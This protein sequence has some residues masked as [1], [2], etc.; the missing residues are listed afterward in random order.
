MQFNIVEGPYRG[1]R[2]HFRH[3]GIRS[4]F[5]P[6]LLPIEVSLIKFLKTHQ[7]DFVINLAYS[8]HLIGKYV[9]QVDLAVPDTDP[10]AAANPGTLLQVNVDACTHGCFT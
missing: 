7:P 4:G 3:K 1:H 8:H 9:A 5:Y 6:G 2:L 10:C